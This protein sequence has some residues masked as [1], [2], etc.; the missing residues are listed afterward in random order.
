MTWGTIFFVFFGNLGCRSKLRYAVPSVR[1]R[2]VPD[3]HGAPPVLASRGVRQDRYWKYLID[4]NILFG[5]NISFRLLGLHGRQEGSSRAFV[6]PRQGKSIT[7]N[8]AMRIKTHLDHSLHLSSLPSE[9][10][11]KNL[12]LLILIVINQFIES[13]SSHCSMINDGTLLTVLYW[14]LPKDKI[15][16]MCIASC[17][18]LKT[19][20]VEW[21][22]A[23]K[24]TFSKIFWLKTHNLLLTECWTLF[25]RYSVRSCSTAGK[26]RGLLGFYST[27]GFQEP[28]TLIVF[29]LTLRA[30][31]SKL[32]SII[33]KS[34]KI[35]NMMAN[36][37]ET[38]PRCFSSIPR[39]LNLPRTVPWQIFRSGTEPFL[40]QVLSFYSNILMGNSFPIFRNQEVP[41]LQTDHERKHFWLG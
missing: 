33:R 37:L 29:S 1:Q 7:V 2:A 27:P 11:L 22:Y 36:I 32:S 38:E 13:G 5:K 28:G 24:C 21:F 8:A 19:L 9:L 34:L 26:P 6:G 15:R 3:Q 41:Q 17:W 35:S 40:S 14:V 20:M 30:I 10:N 18:K 39:N 16:Q 23:C 4:K 12:Y 31:Q 25:A